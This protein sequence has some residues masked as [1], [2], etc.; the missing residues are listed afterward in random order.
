MVMGGF[1]V[2]SG[3]SGGSEKNRILTVSPLAACLLESME[4]YPID[5]A[6]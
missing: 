2:M 4:T 5:L 3:W 1:L 6:K